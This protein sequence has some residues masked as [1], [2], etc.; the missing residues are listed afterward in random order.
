[1]TA[2]PAPK[3][4]AS[5]MKDAVAPYVEAFERRSANGA[6]GEPEWLEQRRAQAI[7]QF[8][9][10]GFPTTRQENWRFTDIKPIARTQFAPARDASQLRAAPDW[11]SALL[12][13]ADDCRLVFVNG[14]FSATLSFVHGLP[15]GVRVGNLREALRED[16]EL[17]ERHL[18]QYGAEDRNPFAALN[19]AFLEDGAFVY[20]PR[21]TKLDR[22]IELLFLS[23][24]G[25]GQPMVTH[26]R[27]LVVVD[28]GAQAALIESYA[29]PVSGSYWTNTVTEVVVAENAKLEM[30]R[31]Q[32]ESAGA[33]HTAVTHSHQARDSVYSFVTFT[34]GSRLMRHDIHAT[35]GGEGADC[36]VDGLSM[37]RDGQHADYHT[38]M[39][40]AQPNC[41]SWEYFNGVFD[42]HARGVFNGRIIVRPG[43]QKTDSKQTNNSLLLSKHARADSQPQLEIY[44]DDVKCTHGAT[45]GPVGDDQLFYL[46]S[47]GLT[48]TQA[49]AM[50]TYGFG[51]E[52]L[53]VVSI[54][55]LKTALEKIVRGWLG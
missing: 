1:M 44:A 17:I 29:G 4:V 35:L 53:R 36:T 26:P 43:A 18:A 37:L 28:R 22:P 38:V 33:Y 42:D 34:F 39:E 55:P 51:S 31:V 14:H 5:E 7:T 9:E 11:N 52:I 20:V 10:A 16:A 45:L 41:T 32:R 25:E 48:P 13:G 40:H 27:N 12:G 8:A 46:Q 21:D 54:E 24:P 2:P 15:A 30:H 50:L 49:R 19:T 23:V 3:S 6:A 47:R